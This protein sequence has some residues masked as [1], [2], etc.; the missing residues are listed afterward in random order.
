[1]HQQVLFHFLSSGSRHPGLSAK[2]PGYFYTFSAIA[3]SVVET[4]PILC[5]N[6]KQKHI[7]HY[8]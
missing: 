6:A 1:L 4:Y 3:F 7:P 5:Y 2:R 8:N